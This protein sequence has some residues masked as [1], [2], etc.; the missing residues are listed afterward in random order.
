MRAIELTA[1]SMDALQV[2]E[3]AEPRVHGDQVLM[4]VRAAALNHR[5]WDVVHGYYDPAMPLPRVPL[6]DGAGEVVE[7]GPEV[8]RFRVGDRVTTMMT[9]DWISDP[10]TPERFAAQLGTRLDGVL[11]D[12]VM[13]PERAFVRCPSNLDFVQASTLPV[14]G[15]SAYSALTE[16][17]LKLGDTVLVQG[18]G[19]V[20]LF[21]LQ[22]AKQAGA[23]VIATTTR[24]A[25]AATLH[26]LGA[27]RVIVTG[28]A[29]RTAE[30][31]ALATS[32]RGVDIVVDVVG[33]SGFAQQLAVL[34]AGGCIAAVG[35]LGLG[36]P[37]PDFSMAL[38]QRRARLL[39]I[40]TG[41]RDR[42]EALVRV[43]EARP[44]QPVVDRVFA[45]TEHREALVHLG[46]GAHVG[47]VVIA[48]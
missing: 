45:F 43:L 36:N 42:Y 28:D 22:L 17:G 2:V 37:V 1:F 4:R 5:D 20:S 11:R 16:A 27:D 15:L 13:L 24:E 32:G 12:Y 6:S 18:T 38:L 23:T 7:V 34:R 26:A 3:R 8:T 35:L 48:L 9:T 44:L 19:G 30:A 10:Y 39:G 29:S 40:A 14:A 25:H 47:K 31:I 41:S 33:A 21:A 46:S